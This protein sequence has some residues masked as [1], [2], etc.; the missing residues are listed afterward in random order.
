VRCLHGPG[1]CEVSPKPA[2]ADLTALALI[3]AL[4]AGDCCGAHALLSGLPEP[5]AEIAYRAA[6]F[7]AVTLAELG[8][9]AEEFAGIQREALLL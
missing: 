9:S 8:M 3:R 5:G 1:A 6:W 4:M 7:A 2:E